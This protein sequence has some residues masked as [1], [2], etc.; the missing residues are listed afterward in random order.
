MDADEH[1]MLLEL[2]AAGMAAAADEMEGVIRAQ[3]DLP[4]ERD[5]HTHEVPESSLSGGTV[6]WIVAERVARAS[7]GAGGGR[8]RRPNMA[9]PDA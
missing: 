4:A 5:H 7:H 6:E 9:A 3:N 1:R 2:D 8:R